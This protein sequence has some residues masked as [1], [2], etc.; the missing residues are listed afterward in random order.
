MVLHTISSL[1]ST[2]AEKCA[3]PIM[4]GLTLC[5]RGPRRLRNEIANTPDFWSNMRNLHNHDK[6]ADIVF[7]LL[8]VIM[9]DNP[10]AVT[11]DN[12]ES[13]VLLL[14]DF[15]SAGSVGAVI[16]QKR[17]RNARKSKQT[18]PIEPP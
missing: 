3:L 4:K 2:I 16:E 8:T 7:E 13:V 11:A 17:E 5:I 12:Y 18:R 9:A 1:D 15:A 14:N 10:S 6:A